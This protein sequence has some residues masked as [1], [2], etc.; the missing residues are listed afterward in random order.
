MRNEPLATGGTSGFQLKEMNILNTSKQVVE[1]TI[2]DKLELDAVVDESK[3]KLPAGCSVKTANTLQELAAI[4]KAW[5]AEG[6][7]R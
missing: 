3:F 5:L 1:K 4:Q 6:S 7:A 2:I